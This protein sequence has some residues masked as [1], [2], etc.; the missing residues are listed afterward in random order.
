MYI[1][2]QSNGN[3]IGGFDDIKKAKQALN[4]DSEDAR[5]WQV[6]LSGSIDIT[7]NQ[8]DCNARQNCLHSGR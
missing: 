2:V 7:E 1:I 8:K 4:A 3:V 6:D 5:L